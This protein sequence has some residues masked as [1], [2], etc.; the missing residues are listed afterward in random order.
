MTFEFEVG[1]N[2]TTFEISSFMACT[3]KREI[4]IK[5]KDSRGTIFALKGKRKRYY[6]R[7]DKST[8][9]FE[10]HDLDIKCDSDIKRPS[11]NGFIITSYSGNALLNFAG[12]VDFVRDWINN[13]NLNTELD[14]SL[15]V[16]TTEPGNFE[17]EWMVY[18]ELVV[19]GTHA[20]ADRILKKQLVIA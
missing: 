10:G 7:V 19:P 17:K 2:Y 6:T 13:K 9:V 3:V 1:K 12:T 18:P 11:E 5:D 16:A 14:K 4:V 15:V 20:V 8:A